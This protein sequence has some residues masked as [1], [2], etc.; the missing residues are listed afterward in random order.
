MQQFRETSLSL[1]LKRR[2]SFKTLD[3]RLKLAAPISMWWNVLVNIKLNYY[4]TRTQKMIL[5]QVASLLK[6]F[7]TAACRKWF[8]CYGLTTAFLVSFVLGILICTW[9]S[10]RRP[11]NSTKL[12]LL[13]HT[14]YYDY[15][16]FTHFHTKIQL[17]CNKWRIRVNYGNSLYVWRYFMA[18]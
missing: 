10:C 1:S 9:K 12:L 2:D 8:I 6:I 14:L 16:L 11:L 18:L 3:S 17:H 4:S 13:H 7:V 15:N 5:L